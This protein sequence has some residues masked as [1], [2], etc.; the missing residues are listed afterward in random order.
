[1][2]PISTYMIEEI[3]PDTFGFDIEFILN[4]LNEI[5]YTPSLFEIM[6]DI[7]V[8]YFSLGAPIYL[9][10]RQV[11]KTGYKY[12]LFKSRTRLRVGDYIINDD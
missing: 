6:K 4:K 7:W 2:I 10:L 12:R 1:M 8:I 11:M 9:I 5:N 3:S